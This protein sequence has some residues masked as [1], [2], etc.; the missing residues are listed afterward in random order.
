MDR[1]GASSD[2]PRNRGRRWRV[3][4]LLLLGVCACAE[5]EGEGGPT[6][7]V[8]PTEITLG[9][10]AALGG[11]ASFLG[12]QYVHGSLAYFK[13]LNAQG[14]VH[15]RKVRL[16]SY[17]DAYD[18]PR[19][20]AN[21][22]KLITEDGVF[23]LFDYVGTPT[24]VRIIDT[25]HEHGVPAFGFFTGAETLR[26]PFRP[27]IFHLRA[28]Y[29]AEIEGALRYFADTLGF[30][31]IAI[32]YQDDAFGSAVL[33]GAQLAMRRRDTQI[34]TTDT[35]ERGTV[36]VERA[37][38]TISR[39]GAE[40]VIL[41]GTYAPLA[42]FI[43]GCHASGFNPYFHTVSFVGSEAFGR[44]I[45]NQSIDTAEYEKIIVTQVVPSPLGDEHAVVQ[46]YRAA[47]RKHF[48]GDEPNYVAL[49]GYLNAKALD[50]VLRR[51]GR[52]LTRDNLIAA[53]EASTDLDIGI[54]KRVSYGRLDHQGL[55]DIYYSRMTADGNFRIF[56]P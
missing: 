50:A 43:K 41:V 20:V 7:G 54:G 17:D 19:T 46:E 39:S 36:D 40:A 23:M 56:E 34:V 37:V 8:T 55:D 31:K 45:K 25:V 35:Y 47:M 51:A 6:P 1:R 38:G 10:S 12:T 28:S 14:G 9:S 3:A 52:E 26:T 13:D 22:R 29:Y 11:H 5:S 21:T 27:H 16:R 32:M 2:C 48:P 42:R 18:P 30:K 53:F 44:E 33:G 4:A 49:E 15:G 24:S